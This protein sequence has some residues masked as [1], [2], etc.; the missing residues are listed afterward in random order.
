MKDWD[1]FYSKMS[2]SIYFYLIKRLIDWLI[3]GFL[4]QLGDGEAKDVTVLE[5]KPQQQIAIKFSSDLQVGQRCLLTLDYRANL[6]STYDGFYYS[7]Y[8]DKNGSKRYTRSA[9]LDRLHS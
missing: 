9:I 3:D 5:Y 6:S 2:V 1:F 4:S 8:T 7:S